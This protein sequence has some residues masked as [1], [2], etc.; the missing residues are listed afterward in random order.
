MFAYPEGSEPEALE[1]AQRQLQR[2]AAAMLLALS[3]FAARAEMVGIPED[4]ARLACA[5]VRRGFPHSGSDIDPEGVIASLT[6][7]LG[8][9]TADGLLKALGDLTYRSDLWRWYGPL[10]LLAREPG[11]RVGL[12][13][14]LGG[15]LAD[16]LATI[17]LAGTDE[18]TVFAEVDAVDRVAIGWFEPDSLGPVFSQAAKAWWVRRVLRAVRTKASADQIVVFESLVA[19]A[20]VALHRGSLWQ[21]VVP[22]AP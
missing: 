16:L 14:G 22:A 3:D 10:A 15:T 5:A 18:E 17:P 6:L 19:K 11:M 4:Q 21:L 8:A 1:D 2:E 13:E 20:G 9:T 7:A 12:D